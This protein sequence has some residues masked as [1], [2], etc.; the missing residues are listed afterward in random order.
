MKGLVSKYIV[1]ILFCLGILSA[2]SDEQFEIDPVAEDA[3]VVRFTIGDFP[4]HITRASDNS[5]I[6]DNRVEE[7]FI[8]IYDQDNKL[9]YHNFVTSPSNDGGTV[10]THRILLTSNIKN[11]TGGTAYIVANRNE[12]IKNVWFDNPTMSVLEEIKDLKADDNEGN[13]LC[14]FSRKEIKSST[15]LNDTFILER[16]FSAISVY[17][18]NCSEEDRIDGMLDDFEVEKFYLNGT[19]KDGEGKIVPSKEPAADGFETQAPTEE[20]MMAPN[21]TCQYVFPVGYSDHNFYLVVRG[22]FGDSENYT[23]YRAEL[24]DE[25]GENISIRHNIHYKIYIS[26]ATRT[27]YSSYEAALGGASNA[28]V[29][30]VDTHP[31]IYNMVT[32]GTYEMGVS[33]T[34]TYESGVTPYLYVKLTAKDEEKITKNFNA[35]YIKIVTRDKGDG[36]NWFSCNTTPEVETI[37]EQ[38]GIVSKIFKYNVNIEDIQDGALH[39]GLFVVTWFDRLEREVVVRVNPV[40]E[41]NLSI[42]LTGSNSF[43][44]SNYYESI[45][46]ESGGTTIYGIAPKENSGHVRDKGFHFPIGLKNSAGGTYATYSYTIKSKTDEAIKS[47]SVLNNFPVKVSSQ[48]GGEYKIEWDGSD[49]QNNEYLVAH[50]SL[51]VTFENGKSTSYDLY[52]TGF[53]YNHTGSPSAKSGTVKSG[54][55]YYECIPVE[56]TGG[57]RLWLD[58]NYGASASGVYVEVNGKNK[59]ETY[60]DRQPNY[61]Y[62]GAEACGGLYNYADIKDKCIP[63]FK[64]PTAAEWSSMSSST[65]FSNPSMYDAGM[66]YWDPRLKVDTKIAHFQKKK[67]YDGSAVG[68]NETGYYWT[69]SAPYGTD[70]D[71][72]TNFRQYVS[73]NGSNISYAAIQ[74]QGSNGSSVGMSVRC[75]DDAEDNTTSNILN[76]KVKGYT[77]IYLYY[78][79]LNGRRIG[80]NT[81]PGD[82]ITMSQTFTE[83]SPFFEITVSTYLDLNKSKGNCF[84]VVL[85]DIEKDGTIKSYWTGGNKKPWKPT[86]KPLSLAGFRQG[87]VNDN[88]YVYEYPAEVAQSP[89]YFDTYGTKWADNNAVIKVEYKTS[90]GNNSI[91]DMN[92][93]METSMTGIYSVS[94]PTDATDLIFYSTGNTDYKTG[95]L[96]AV[97]NHVYRP[98]GDTG[99]SISEYSHDIIYFDTYES[100]WSGKTLT[101]TCSGSGT[102]YIHS[103]VKV[104]DMGMW[105]I[106]VPFGD[107]TVKFKYD[108]SHETS[109]WTIHNNHVYTPDGD[110]GKTYSEYQRNMSKI[111]IYFDNSEKNWSSIQAYAYWGGGHDTDEEDSPWGGT[112]MVKYDNARNIWKA[113]ID[114][115]CTSLIIH[116]GDNKIENLTVYPNHVYTASGDSGKT[117]DEYIATPVTPTTYTVYWDNSVA[118]WSEPYAQALKGEEKNGWPGD[119]MTKINGSDI[120][121]VSLDKKYEKLYF[122]N[123]TNDGVGRFPLIDGHIYSKKGDRGLYNPATYV[124]Q[125]AEDAAS[126]DNKNWVYFD[127]TGTGISNTPMVAAF[128]DNLDNTEP[129]TMTQ[130]AG[131]N[132]Y[133]YELPANAEK[134]IFMGSGGWNDNKSPADGGYD[135]V[136]GK[137]YNTKGEV[138]LYFRGYTGFNSDKLMTWNASMSR[139][140]VEITKSSNFEF[141]IA[142]SDYKLFDFGGANALLSLPYDEKIYSGGGNIN[143][144]AS[145]GNYMIYFYMKNNDYYIS[146]EKK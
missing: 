15:D 131:T 119:K 129:Q 26:S 86:I 27:G 9:C 139:Y 95:T 75:I 71:A 106:E 104:D 111:T 130:I 77:H 116:S 24:K 103:M 5:L 16:N 140:E 2:C 30:I 97:S 44:L 20:G 68:D 6:K 124:T 133:K 67:Y 56:T 89:I 80:I 122:S 125:A 126:E 28:T 137:I 109:A 105:K 65:A 33:D 69:S 135:F 17:D 66:T 88:S 8:A 101:A 49:A 18:K 32:D 132:F 47:V 110:T 142:D 53:F 61:T 98:S 38:G 107:K 127:K 76:F 42:S 48:G 54:I 113:E 1:F 57:V 146:A 64:V 108:D 3:P 102:T 121:S 82:R 25:K 7:V 128:G 84:Y 96:E 60:Q 43:S 14:F 55:H 141:K 100:D 35:D 4:V 118:G 45:S 91:E 72:A 29:K 52:H 31:Q 85:T 36:T 115:R 87:Y 73:M 13:Y 62:N 79:D 81:W 58:R 136:K 10:Y 114:S 123:N 99:K 59:F 41:N 74:F 78:Y 70:G 11:L 93:L 51:V 120:Y 37:Q 145:N 46:G 63:G 90:D 23:Y 34:I 92:L 22:K 50:N 143:F 138:K 117:Y 40:F 19:P 144:S 94:I 112:N 39:E 21:G 12:L 83:N 134:V